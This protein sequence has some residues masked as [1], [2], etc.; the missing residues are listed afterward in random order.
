MTAAGLLLP[1]F[2]VYVEGRLVYAC[3]C[4]VYVRS[5]LPFGRSI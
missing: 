1:G 5:G 4:M 2:Q 3:G